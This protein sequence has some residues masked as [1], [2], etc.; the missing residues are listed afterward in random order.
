MSKL[1]IPERDDHITPA[2]WRTGLFIGLSIAI[3]GRVVELA[4]ESTLPNIFYNYQIY[5][6]FG[7]PVLFCLAF[8]INIVV[9]HRCHINYKFIFEFDPRDNLSYH[10]VAEVTV[11][12]SIKKKNFI[13]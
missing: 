1:R 11:V 5:S 12:Y 2:I 6:C 7:I 3:F 10:Q 13:Y 8:T 4:T 9:W